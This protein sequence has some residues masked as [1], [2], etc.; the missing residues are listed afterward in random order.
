[1]DDFLSKSESC[2]LEQSIVGRLLD[3]GTDVVSGARFA[4][5][6]K[7]VNTPVQRSKIS[8]QLEFP[9]VCDRCYRE[10]TGL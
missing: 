10:A 4:S 2:N 5:A 8:E 6:D 7:P 9:E 1:M 3:D